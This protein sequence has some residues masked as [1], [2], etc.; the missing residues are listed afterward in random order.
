MFNYGELFGCFVGLF[1]GLFMEFYV[2]L[3]FFGGSL[4]ALCG[5]G[6]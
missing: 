2:V 4:P 3:L 5:F 1:I 6:P